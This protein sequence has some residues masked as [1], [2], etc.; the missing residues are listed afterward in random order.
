MAVSFFLLARET[1]TLSLG[2]AYA[3]WTGVGVLD[4]VIVGVILFKEPM[5]AGRLVFAALLLI[6]VVGLKLMPA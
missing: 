4:S 1:K 2:T 6:G 5:M 3:V